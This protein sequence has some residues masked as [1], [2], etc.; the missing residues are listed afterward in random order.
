MQVE[1]SIQTNGSARAL[2]TA[3]PVQAT[4]EGPVGNEPEHAY[5]RN[6]RIY[7]YI[8]SFPTIG[9]IRIR[10]RIRRRRGYRLSKYRQA[11]GRRISHERQTS[12]YEERI[13][14]DDVGR[15]DMPSTS[16]SP[17]RRQ[18]TE[19]ESL[20]GAEIQLAVSVYIKGSTWTGQRP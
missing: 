15:K 1:G 19:A 5:G 13:A 8:G 11:D 12:G 20:K 4:Q 6:G 3:D 18:C 17:N 7:G 16:L 2:G 10:N 9:R 14:H